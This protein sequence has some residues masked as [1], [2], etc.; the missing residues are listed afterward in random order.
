MHGATEVVGGQQVHPA[1]ADDGGRLNA[2]E[3]PL[4]RRSRS[5]AR[6]RPASWPPG[7]GAVGG[8]GEVEEVGALGIVELQGSGERVEHRCRNPAERAAL[9]QYSMLTP[10]RAATSRGAT[11]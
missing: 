8:V 3:H 9:Q 1:V 10:A 5:P 2:I 7:A 6:T 11:P 4:Q